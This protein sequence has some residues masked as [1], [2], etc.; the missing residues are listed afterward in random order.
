M[1]YR[2]IRC[3]TI[4]AILLFSYCYCVPISAQ[5]E[6]QTFLD[7]KQAEAALD[8]AEP[9]SL[10]DW[11][12]LF[13]ALNT[14]SQGPG[15]I[16]SFRELWE[17]KPGSI[18]GQISLNGLVIRRFRRE[19]VGQFPALEELWVRTDDDGLILVTSRSQ[20][21]SNDEVTTES[22]PTGPGRAITVTGQFL[23]KIR[24]E[25][26]DSPRIA[27]WIVAGTITPQVSEFLPHTGSPFGGS[28]QNSLMM[29]VWMI[30]A[31]AA[32]LRLIMALIN[33]YATRS[34]FPHN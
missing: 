2:M 18:L 4:Q 19:A 5:T 26:T 9:V 7:P 17:A 3:A 1:I 28:S 8:T 11:P 24:Y 10:A 31:S 33:R 6:D 15:R 25:A 32:G 23:R 21:K 27:P 13:R 30:V 29:T 34:K 16:I 14:T 20:S 12:A 22:D